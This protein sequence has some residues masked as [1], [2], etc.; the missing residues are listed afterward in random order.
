MFVVAGVSGNTGKIVA[1][2]LLAQ[3]KPVR[4]VVRDASKGEA[5]KARGAEVA[6]ADLDDAGAL[7]RALDGAAGAYLLLPPHN[8]SSAAREDNAKRTAA[9]A[10]ALASS[11]VGHVVFLSSVGAQHAA[12]TGP[13]LSVHDAEAALAKAHPNVTFVR[14]A[15][16]MENWGGS[17]YG[18]ASGTLPTFLKLDRAIP[19][20]AT[21]DIGTT[22]AK[23]LVEGGKGHTVIELSGPREYSPRDVAAALAR[24]SGKPIAAQEGPEEA[25]VPALVG[26]GMNAHWAGLFDEMIRGVNAGH[27]AWEGGAARAVRGTTEVDEV[28]RG[29][30]S[31]A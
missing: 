3:K 10:A 25:I 6:I 27:V 17:L 8:A 23:A 4:V 12:G 22:I 5:W 14:A 24:V 15:Y 9:Y 2:T 11:R 7:S 13:I 26:A 16:F 19:M 29:L 31:R 1:E 30:L 28:L 20:V 18:L 21:K